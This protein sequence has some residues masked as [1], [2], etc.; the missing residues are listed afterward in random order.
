[1]E[2]LVEENITKEI[3]DYEIERGKPIPTLIHGAI[4]FNLGFE[5]KSNYTDKF[6][7]ASEVTLATQPNG[8]VPDLVLYPKQAL[9]YKNDPSKREDAPL[10]AIEIQSA[11]QSTK[12]MV[13]KL[14][15]YFYF[16]M[17]SCWIVIPNLQAILVYDSPFHY[18]F[19]HGTEILHDAILD[20][21]VDLK[22]IFE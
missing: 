11:S 18:T 1:M 4:Q 9:D 20:I 8:S 21:Q 22:K 13:D 2:L 5:I 12:D 16:G 10:L 19:F 7:I 15:P 17:K 6:R 3:S 14:E